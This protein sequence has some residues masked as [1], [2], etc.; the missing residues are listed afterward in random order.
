[1]N[2]NRVF[3]VHMLCEQAPYSDVTFDIVIFELSI[4]VKQILSYVMEGAR[5]EEKM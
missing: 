2:L 1:M 3:F 4:H 5:V